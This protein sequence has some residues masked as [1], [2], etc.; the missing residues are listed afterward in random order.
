[1]WGCGLIAT[2]SIQKVGTHQSISPVLIV[3][4]SFL[5]HVILHELIK[6]FFTFC[7][8]YLQSDAPN[9][10]DLKIKLDQLSSYAK[11]ANS[12]VASANDPAVSALVQSASSD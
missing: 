5:H 3:V 10:F 12:A 2:I 6:H 1:M 4:Y 7:V 8:P 9:C 11:A